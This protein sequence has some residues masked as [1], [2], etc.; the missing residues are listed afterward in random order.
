QYDRSWNPV[1]D[2]ETK[3]DHL[4]SARGNLLVVQRHKDVLRIA[5]IN[6]V[7]VAVQHVDVN[8]MRVRIHAAVGTNPAGSSDDPITRFRDQ[9]HPDLVGID[10]PLAEG[11][12]EP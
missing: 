3:V 5:A 7:A 11:M 8:E 2:V 4:S 1:R 12:T 6:S 10:R 9:F